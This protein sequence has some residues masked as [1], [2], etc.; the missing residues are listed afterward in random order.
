MNDVA[1]PN[2]SAPATINSGEAPGLPN[3]QK[4]AVI[5]S[6]VD[7]AD[8]AEI[9]K[10]FSEETLFHF[11]K[12]INELKPIPPQTLEGVI[13]EFLL[14][15]GEGSSIR[16]G[17]DQVRVYLEQFLDDDNVDRIIKDI[18]DQQTRPV[19]DRLADAPTA[20][21]AHYLALE[22][23][24][25]VAVVLSKLRSDRAAGIL[26]LLDR[27]LAQLSI[28]RM[29]RVP[30]IDPET[31]SVVESAIDRD[32]LSAM[33]RQSGNVKPAELIGNLMNNVSSE[34]RDQFLEHLETT[35]SSLAQE[36]TR[37]MFTFA[38]VATRVP[39]NAVGGIIKDTEE[40]TLMIALKFAKDKENP[41]YDFI[42]SNVSKRLS[43]RLV[44][45]IEAMESPKEKEAEAAQ[46]V[47]VNAIR[48]QAKLGQNH[49][50]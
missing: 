1:L 39:A 40:E 50:V 37:V 30:S 2:A 9:L 14:E 33:N 10:G 15:L 38:D 35:D 46:M 45:D 5:L 24:Q 4:A 23:P 43:E 18:A 34:A 41:T 25:T 31:V 13:V 20:A 29:S 49:A 27:E 44:E 22:H 32:F 12:A 17:M 16:G 6:I 3:A 8:A 19:W 28:M 47:I 42:M 7:P 11:A 36:V 21:A 48:N 26:E